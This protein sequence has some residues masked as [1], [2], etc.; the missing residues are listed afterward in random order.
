MYPPK[1]FCKDFEK[2]N[3][4]EYHNLHVQDDTLLLA[5]AFNNF[6]SIY[7]E[8][9]ELDSAHVLFAPGLAWQAT[10]KNTKVIRDLLTDTDISLMIEKYI[11]LEVE[12]VM[13]FIDMRNLMTNT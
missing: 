4:R 7:L 6:Q 1:K 5:D 10:L 12:Y 3:L 8:K 11:I 2:E 9:Y 13:L